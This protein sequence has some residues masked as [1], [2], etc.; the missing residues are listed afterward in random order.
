MWA[1]KSRTIEDIKKLIDEEIA[2]VNASDLDYT[3]SPF[4]DK[5]DHLSRL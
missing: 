4:K 2:D 1:N 3:G 5:N